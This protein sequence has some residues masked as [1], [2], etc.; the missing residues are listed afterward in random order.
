LNDELG[1]VISRAF[2]IWERTWFYEVEFDQG[3]ILRLPFS[4]IVEMT[5][6]D[7][8][9]HAKMESEQGGN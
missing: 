9:P 1:T 4:A 2:D 3:G 7:G 6:A 8:K 5:C